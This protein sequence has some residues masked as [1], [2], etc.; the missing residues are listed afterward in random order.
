MR[1]RLLTLATAVMLLALPLSADNISTSVEQVTSAINLDTDV[2]YHI[3]GTTPFA[4]TGSINIT[5]TEH[6][7]IIFD[8]LKPSEAMKYLAAYVMINGEKANYSTNCQVKMYGQGSIVMPYAVDFKPLT[9][10]SEKNFKG[11]AVNDF[12]LENSG[13]YMV[14]LTDAKL[15]NKIRSFKL[16][17]GYMVT[18]ATKQ[19]GYGYSRCFVADNADLEMASLPDVLDH[20]ISSYRIF[21]WNDVSKKGLANDNRSATNNALRTTWSYEF[22]LGSDG[23]VD[24]EV[25]PMH[26]KEGWPS[27]SACGSVTYSPNLKTNNE[28]ANP[29]DDPKDNPESVADCLSDWDD[30]MRTGMRLCTPS[31]WDGSPNFIREFLDSIDARGWRCD[32]VDVHS[33]WTNFS[34]LSSWYNNYHRPLWISEW[35]WG[36]SWNNNG[37]FNPNLSNDERLTQNATRI[38]EIC[39]QMNSMPYVERYAYWN[40][41]Q[42]YSRIYND[43]ALTPAGEYYAAMDPGMAYNKKYEYIP[44][45]PRLYRPFALNAAFKPNRSLCV[46]TW[47]SKNGDFTDSVYL[48]R[49]TG[50]YG[51]WQTLYKEAGQD[52]NETSYTFNDEVSVAGEYT[53]RVREVSYLGTELISDEVYNTVTGS[54]GIE[55]VQF[56]RISSTSTDETFN[57]FEYPFVEMPTIV[58]GSVSNSNGAYPVAENYMQSY[59]INGNYSYFKFRYF[60]WLSNTTG[61]FKNTEASNYIA[62]KT[63][64]G[65]I[66]TLNYEA[67]TVMNGTSK[68]IGSDVTE[69]KFAKP[70]DKKPVVFVTPK[71]QTQAYPYFWRIFDVTPEGFKIV[72]QREKITESSFANL[73]RVEVGYF[74]IDKG[75]SSDGAGNLYTVADETVIFNSLVSKKISYTNKK[76]PMVLA[77]MQ[78]NQHPGAG[79]LRLQYNPGATSCSV[80]L[81]IDASDPDNA[82]LTSTNKAEENIGYIIISTDTIATSIQDINIENAKGGKLITY[83]SEDAVGVNDSHATA[84]MLY[85]AGGQIIAR[86]KLSEGRTTFDIANLPKGV[87]IIRTDANHTTKFIKK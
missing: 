4:T 9:V 60:P 71:Y 58:M 36:A 65:K 62:A 57:Y 49:K 82:R 24:R 32:I 79:Q 56:G 42:W 1:K 51:T 46:I 64:N 34:Q 66:G 75:E 44:R 77:Q 28:P 33:Y 17:R 25:T 69:V 11:T 10:Y 45:Q 78:T 59:K 26:V 38:K 29:A 68:L 40:S 52:L 53:Y 61:T 2:D 21:K 22:S 74:A 87:Y 15:N 55:D 30:L 14:T 81:Q 39:E 20:R 70:F 16:K 6:A 3:S 19:S 83:L 84:A 67:G 35:V 72:M 5:N 12:G 47:K 86:Q 41:E 54:K 37:V 43:N 13:G 85:N 80:K 76:D 27:P 7:V 73:A 31:S 48:E 18:F 50:K 8:K 23:G 63:G